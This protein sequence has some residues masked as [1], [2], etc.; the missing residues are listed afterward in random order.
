MRMRV[1]AIS[2][3]ITILQV[4][5]PDPRTLWFLE[6]L[7]EV[8]A[9]QTKERQTWSITVVSQKKEVG[10]LSQ[11]LFLVLLECNKNIPT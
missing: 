2:G 1:E 7:I 10:N 9:K 3:K 5:T 8:M 4:A 6:I 11:S